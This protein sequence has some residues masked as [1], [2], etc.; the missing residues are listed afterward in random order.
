MVRHTTFRYCLDPTVEQQAVLAKHAG[1]ARFAFNQSLRAV[2][3][4]LTRRRTDPDVAVPWSGFDLINAFN[5]WKKTADAGRVFVV[6][7]EGVAEIRV[8]GLA[9]R[10]EVC[11]QVFEE[12]AVDC[13]RALAAWSASRTGAR[14][15]RKVGFPRFKKK[16]GATPSFRLRNKQRTGG[17]PPIRVGDTR[18]RSVTLPGVGAVRVH[19]DT[20]RLRRL[21]G[22][23]RGRILFATV[24]FRGGRWWVSLNVDA[25]DLH[26][27]QHH[28]PRP[29]N[30][31][32]GWVG[33]DRGL[34][35][36]LVAAT[37]DGREVARIDDP[38]KALAAGMRRQR[39]L[40][41]TVS[42]K[43][44]GSHNRTRAAARLGR[45]HKKVRDIRRHFLNE[46]S[47]ALVKT[48]DRIALEDLHVTGMLANH[49]LAR[50]ISDAAWAEFAR[51]LRYKQAWRHGDIAVVDRWFPSSKTCSICGTVNAGL[52]LSDR[53][54]VCVNGHRLDRDHN[55]AINLAAWAENHHGSDADAQVRDP[56]AGGPVT[57]ARRQDGPG[58]HS[59]V[60]E[61]S[62]EDAGTDAHPTAVA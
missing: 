62:L 30:D 51:M 36:F 46:V 4:A 42:R 20:R 47:N 8:T 3:T 17:R 1:A 10:T 52:T 50:A 44:K 45:H 15:G 39:R 11:Q 21:L 34:T 5:T 40:A 33:I 6:D 56:Q 59:G 16:S 54:F 14:T 48:H 37:A 18:P 55:A 53:A 38:P 31:A 35:T 7:A 26:P 32:G 25:T 60:G 24:S 23:G 12:A 41:K 13:G 58:P 57:N 22:K 29:E 19:D 61:T 27:A 43:E 49:R 9:W 2:K 28:P